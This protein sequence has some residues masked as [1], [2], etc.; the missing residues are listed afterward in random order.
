MLRATFNR[1]CAAL[2]LLLL[3]T[4]AFASVGKVMFV[5]GGASIERGKTAVA[6]QRGQH[7]ESG[8]ILVTSLSGRMHV[9]MDD[10]AVITLKPD[11]R[12]ELTDYAVDDEPESQPTGTPE[13]TATTPAEA[14]LVRTRSSGRAFMS[15][16]KGGFRTITGLIGKADKEA[17][18]IKT[19]VA[20]IG[21]RGTHYE[22]AVVDGQ[23]FLAVWDGSIDINLP[24]G[25]VTFGQNQRFSFGVVSP[26]GTVTGLD[27]PP[28]V[29]GTGDTDPTLDLGDTAPGGGSADEDGDEQ[30]DEQRPI[31][32][33]STDDPEELG[34]RVNDPD[35]KPDPANSVAAG[36]GPYRGTSGFT[37]AA[38]TQGAAIDANGALTRFGAGHP[39]GTATYDI[40]T[41][42]ATNTGFDPDSGI[43]W[44]RWADGVAQIAIVDG[45][46]ENL[47][48]SSQSLHYI[49][50]PADDAPVIPITGA[51]SYTLVGN[52]NP[53]DGNGNV[54]V[55]GSASLTANF[56]ERTVNSVIDLA[57]S[58]TV[59]SASGSGTIGDD[60]NLFDGNYDTVTVNGDS[61]GNSGIFDGF[62]SGDNDGSGLPDGAGLIYNLTNGTDS[63]TG[64]AV[65]GEP[66][67]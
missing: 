24:T 18:Q 19:P 45:A 38:N 60:S 15:L 29:F 11:S 40:G 66:S 22:I 64:G 9:R 16:L 47:D 25:T 42:T 10:G 5:L 51:A 28:E 56:T 35:P 65:F 8:D 50:G 53:T 67:P 57:I 34:D 17:Y 26:D 46:T 21:I 13:A 61:A 2:V 37:T 33:A 7:L 31:E 62:F 63:V 4:P 52:T 32:V 55:L 59:W 41:A 58:D 39:D 54:G 27:E 6:A 43:R 49:A 44:G 12:F 14:P 23:L 36:S 48:L 1:A 20:T 3:A 30:S